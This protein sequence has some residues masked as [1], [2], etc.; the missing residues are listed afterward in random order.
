MLK[1]RYQVYPNNKGYY[2]LDNRLKKVLEPGVYRL[3]GWYRKVLLVNVPFTPQLLRILNQEVLTKDAIS[4]RFSYMIGY[5]VG[6]GEKYL[7]SFDFGPSPD[8]FGLE[9]NNQLH[10]H[11]QVVL[12]NIIAQYP[13][14][15]INQHRET[16]F[17]DARAALEK[18]LGPLGLTIREVELIDIQFPKNIQDIFALRLEAQVRAQS[19][20]ENAR[21]Q[22][23]S[24]RALKNAAELMKGDQDI[25][26][27]QWLDTVREI[28]KK[29]KHTFILGDGKN[30]T[31]DAK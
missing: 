29:G 9:V 31:L 30:L 10:S 28:S 15:E 8:S 11:S 3:G 5:Q 13:S 21:T 18:R 14:E 25:R 7:A 2:F 1:K 26:F 6:D 24:A 22:V 4:L 12:R 27:L 16:L 23:A 17:S 19:E 20:L